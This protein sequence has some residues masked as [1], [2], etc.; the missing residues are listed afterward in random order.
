MKWINGHGITRV[1]WVCA[2]LVFLVAEA[3]LIVASLGLPEGNSSLP[4]RSVILNVFLASIPAVVGL[5]GY[6]AVRGLAAKANMDSADTTFVWLSRQFL[7]AAIFAYVALLFVV[8]S[9][10]DAW[11]PK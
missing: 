9:L 11:H 1:L 8:M 3:V 4:V 6:K 7:I 10:T 2:L 5:S